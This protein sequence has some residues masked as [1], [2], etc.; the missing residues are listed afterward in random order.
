MLVCFEPL[1]EC[2]WGVLCWWAASS[3]RSFAQPGLALLGLIAFPGEKQ[4]SLKVPKPVACGGM[5]LGVGKSIWLE[6]RGGLASS[7][8]LNF[9]LES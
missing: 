5:A 8:F 4:G 6:G 1:P 3:L 2:C 7:R 9:W